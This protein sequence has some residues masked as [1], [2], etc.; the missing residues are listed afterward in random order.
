MSDVL[1]ELDFTISQRLDKPFLQGA[2]DVDYEDCVRPVDLQPMREVALNNFEVVVHQAM[3]LHRDAPARSDTWLGPRLHQALRLTRRE[4]ARRGTWRY[5]AVVACPEYV[6]WRWGD[7]DDIESPAKI[8]RFVGPDYKHAFARLWWMA[9]LFRDGPDYRPAAE[10]LTNQ[11]IANNL[12]RMD[13]A[14]HRPTVQAAVRVLSG[15]TGDEANALAKAVNAAAATQ[16]LDAMA[17]DLPLDGSATERWVMESGDVDAQAY[18][19]ELPPGPDDPPVPAEGIK[20]ME[21]QLT[22]LLA[23]APVRER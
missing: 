13:V 6:R 22:E 18:F 14:H 3:T 20:V 17:A 7:P 4:A 15:R 21:E 11:D 2:A 5:L 1:M 16:L 23:A 9:E 8:E 19:D 10:A 12:F